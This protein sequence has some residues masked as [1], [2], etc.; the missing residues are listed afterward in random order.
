MTAVTDKSTLTAAR[1][2]WIQVDF[3]ET[4][5]YNTLI[6]IIHDW[7]LNLEFFSIEIQL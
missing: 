4:T 7:R 5:G 2:R 6:W 1:S 3:D